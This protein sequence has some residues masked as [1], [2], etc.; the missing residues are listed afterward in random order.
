MSSAGKSAVSHDYEAKNGNLLKS[1]YANGWEVTYTYDNLDRVT[2]VKASKDG[3]YVN[4][5]FNGVFVGSVAYRS[6]ASLEAA[7]ISGGIAALFSASGIGDLAGLELVKDGHILAGNV[8]ATGS[9]D[10]VV[11]T[12]YMGMSSA[13]SAAATANHKSGNTASSKSKHGKKGSYMNSTKPRKISDQIVRKGRHV[14]RVKKYLYLGR[15]YIE[16]DIIK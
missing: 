9:I 10:L 5:V 4:A 3:K 6:G 1:T 7:W 13:V 2:E 12:G 8:V 16:W 15:I 11:N 14:Y